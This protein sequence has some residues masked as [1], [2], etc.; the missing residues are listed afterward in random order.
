[1]KKIRIGL[2]SNN[3]LS[4]NLGVGAL[5][6]SNIALLERACTGPDL[7]IQYMI[8]ADLRRKEETIQCIKTCLSKENIRI[9]VVPELEFRGGYKSLQEFKKNIC[10]CNMVFDT[11]GG[12]SFADIYGNNRI[13]HQ[14]YIK[15]VCITNGI[16]LILTPQTIG[17]FN[18]WFWEH[19]ASR[20]LKACKRVYVRDHKSYEYTSNVLKCS[21]VVEV[22]DM[23]MALPYN[24]K[25]KILSDKRC[26]GVNVSGLLF[27]GGYSKN[28]QFGLKC[29]YRMLVEK[30]IKRLL[31]KN[32]SVH[33][34]PHV[35][36]TGVESDNEVCEQLQNKFPAT[37]Y[38]GVFDTPV[39]A[40]NYI[41]EMD[42]FIGARMHSTIAAFS[43]GVPVIPL[44]Y[45][46]K[47][48]GLF[49]SNN[50]YECIDMKKNT[51]EEIA[52]LVIRKLEDIANIQKC[53]LQ[54]K[55]IV[56]EKINRYVKDLQNVIK[57]IAHEN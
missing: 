3:V 5:G 14:I 10:S 30:L 25:D 40:K 31:A 38:S 4:G 36:T 39:E 15:R 50:Y 33:L 46:R 35:I 19:A 24:S 18:S 56:E 22:T 27:H 32:Y 1:M 37:V 9:I 54:S 41:K 28:N 12:D 2:L 43:T 17:P 57:E 51:E 42:F 47:F 20:V 6:I 7:D 21:N 45:S 34:I 8:F 11:S 53:V 23:A 29:N 52:T 26:V 49:E 48:E 55:N 44:S 13:F 16:P